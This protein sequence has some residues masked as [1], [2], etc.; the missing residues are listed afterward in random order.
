MHTFDGFQRNG[1]ALGQSGCTNFACLRGT[2]VAVP[3]VEFYPS[4][5]IRPNLLAVV[6][7]RLELLPLVIRP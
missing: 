3:L 7:V 1:F 5:G 2:L 4:L 6:G